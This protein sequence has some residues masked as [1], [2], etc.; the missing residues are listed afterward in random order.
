MAPDQSGQFGLAEA[1]T[2]PPFAARVGF[3]L[4]QVRPLNLGENLVRRQAG[5]DGVP[6]QHVEPIAPGVGRRRE[7]ALLVGF[8]PLGKFLDS[9]ADPG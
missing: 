3:R 8:D 4:G 9:H 7:I 5:R 1:G 2:F 6:Q